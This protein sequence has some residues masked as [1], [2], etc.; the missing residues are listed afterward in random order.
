MGKLRRRRATKFNKVMQRPA[1][2]KE[3]PRL[4]LRHPG[5]NGALPDARLA[6]AVRWV[7]RQAAN[8]H[9]VV[10]EARHR[11][12]DRDRR[13]Q[14]HQRR[15]GG[16]IDAA[17]RRSGL[18]RGNESATRIPLFHYFFHHLFH[19]FLVNSF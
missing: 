18:R 9:V 17:Y 8:S 10:H 3:P 4:W 7:R 11:M 16:R 12:I 2:C 5:R 1:A 19:H 13:R 15:T 14:R 6:G